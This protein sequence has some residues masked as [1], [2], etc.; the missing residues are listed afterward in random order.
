[1][2]IRVMAYC[3]VYT[4]QSNSRLLNIQPPVVSQ[5]GC[6]Q[7]IQ[8][9]IVGYLGWLVGSLHKFSEGMQVSVVTKS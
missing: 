3:N 1:M 9:Q 2:Y 8:I 4:V 5:V 7:T 6:Q